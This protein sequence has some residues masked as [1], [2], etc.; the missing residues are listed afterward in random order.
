MIIEMIDARL[1]EH[2]PA[3]VHFDGF[4]PQRAGRR[5]R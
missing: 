1:V 2:I 4:P 5:A 3:T